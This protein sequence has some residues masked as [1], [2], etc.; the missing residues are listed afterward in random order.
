MRA[1]IQ[2]APVEYGDGAS[3]QT[4]VGADGAVHHGVVKW[5][6][7]TRGFGFVVADDPTV[8]D[9]LIHFSIL[10]QHGRRSLPEG[11]RVECVAVERRRGYQAREILS[12]DLSDAVEPHARDHADRSDRVR[13]IEAAGP[14]EPVS[15][16][17]FNRLKGYGFLVRP[18]DSGDIFVHIETLR[19]AGIEEVEPDQPLQARVVDGEKGPLAVA[20]EAA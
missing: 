15:V 17:W 19:A 5:F 7:V 1:D 13:L 14:F 4:E 12:I 6:D 16:K 11:A 18:N 10:Q 3:S 2:R 20:V 8:G 9:I